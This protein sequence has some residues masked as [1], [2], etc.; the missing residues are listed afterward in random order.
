MFRLLVSANRGLSFS[1]QPVIA[2]KN[3]KYWINYFKIKSRN[4]SP[5]PIDK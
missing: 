4:L 2:E 3:N 1:D 5:I